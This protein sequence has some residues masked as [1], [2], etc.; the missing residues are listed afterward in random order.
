[1][2]RRGKQD[3]MNFGYSSLPFDLAQGGELLELFPISG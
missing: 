1:M 2:G 3:P